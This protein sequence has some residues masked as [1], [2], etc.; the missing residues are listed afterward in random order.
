MFANQVIVINLMM[1][2]T[3]FFINRLQFFYRLL[4]LS[5]KF[6]KVWT[7][8]YVGGLAELR[9]LGDGIMGPTLTCLVAENFKKLKYSD[10]YFYESRANPT[11]FKQCIFFYQ[12]VCLKEVYT[13]YTFV[14][15]YL[16]QLAEIKKASKWLY[17]I[18]II[19]KLI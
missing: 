16:A 8:L 5:P 18:V 4:T 11:P 17:I 10:R 13:N 19:F 6:T 12:Y 15:F 7:N 9:T 1:E 3:R 14:Y 2:W